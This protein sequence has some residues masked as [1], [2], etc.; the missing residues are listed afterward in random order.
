MLQ[1]L[2]IIL[3]KKNVKKYILIAFLMLI[4]SLIDTFSVYMV[5]PFVYAIMEPDA[6]TMST[7]TAVITKI[8]G[9]VNYTKMI[10]IIAIGIA[11]LYIV[12]NAYMIM[13][14]K[15]KHTFIAKCRTEA[16]TNLFRN[17]TKKEYSYFTE[18]NTSSIQRL[19]ITDIE[20]TMIVIDSVLSVFMELITLILI[21]IMLMITDPLLTIIAGIAIFFIASLVNRPIAKYVD[22][23]SKRY[24]VFYTGMLKWTQQFVGSLKDTLATNRRE[25]FVTRFEADCQKYGV[26]RGKY[27]YLANIS[28]YITNAVIM[29]S[30]FIYV[31]F[32]ASS[33]GNISDRIPEFALFALCAI[34]LMPSITTILGQINAIRYHMQGVEFVYEHINQE[35]E[36]T[37]NIEEKNTEEQLKLQDAIEINNLSFKFKDEEK[38]LFHNVSLRIPAHKSTAFIGTTGSG[39]TTLA[40]I[41][42]G[43]QKPTNGGVYVDG[44]NINDNLA[45]WANTIGYIPQNIYLIE[46]TIKSNI[47]F[48]IPIEKIDEDKVWKCIEAAQLS[49]Y[50]EKLPKGIE[51]ITGENGVKLSGGQKQ[52]LGIARALYRNP[53][54]LVLDEATSALDS[55]TEGAVMDVIEHLVGK[56]TILIIA[57]RL[58]TIENCD[59]V[60]KIDN[61]VISQDKERSG[62]E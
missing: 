43:L 25:Y 17:I 44:I 62:N 40:D 61:G 52:R 3:G 29:A 49:D 10:A 48:G 13:L 33:G 14:N 24:T 4:G 23:L 22:K 7:V 26:T 11:I 1:K 42:L 60:Y 55:D 41:I 54:F 32:L 37:I 47:A 56:M 12:R 30:V 6:F 27:N 51:T 53:S 2:R 39:K 46:D 31:A 16:S 19:C 36:T 9:N 35:K 34:K 15:I 45:K 58:T 50:I 38:E 18:T 57:H 8:W 28:G 5:L 21:I 20:R 59:L